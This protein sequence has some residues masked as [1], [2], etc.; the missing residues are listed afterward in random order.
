VAK[1]PVAA[2]GVAIALIVP[3]VALA[4]TPPNRAYPDSADR[5][6]LIT[7]RDASRTDA[8]AI[9]RTL[10][11]CERSA[12]DPYGRGRVAF[13]QCILTPLNRLLYESRFEPAMLVGVLRDL[14][15]GR[16]AAVASGVGN[17][18]SQLGG[19]AETWIGDAESSDSSAGALERADAHDMRAIARGTIA[20]AGSRSWRQ[21][22]RARPYQPSEHHVLRVARV[23]IA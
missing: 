5:T 20:L 12:P 8:A 9:L 1:R 22:C 10:A 23:F 17:A 6:T 7:L 3:G 13:N 4:R 15:P 16:C 18:I 21:A 14:A 19:E 11:S 2:V